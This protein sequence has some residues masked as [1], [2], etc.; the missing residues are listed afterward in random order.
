MPRPNVAVIMTDQQRAD[1]SRAEGFGLDTTPHLDE[2]GAG[3]VRFERAYTPIPLCSP[4]RISMLTGRYPGAH[5]I[6]ENYGL[7]AAVYDRDLFDV[8]GAEGYATAL[9]GKNHAH[10]RPEE[11]DHASV[12][13]HDGQRTGC[14]TREEEEFDAGSG[15]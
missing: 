8:L 3:G 6:R 1:V 2:L 13:F 5:R 14:R 7:R 4:A 11:L 9:I 15:R 12:Y 10:V